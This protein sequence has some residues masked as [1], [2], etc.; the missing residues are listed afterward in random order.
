MITKLKP[1]PRSDK[2]LD[3]RMDVAS[4][5]TALVIFHSVNMLYEWEK[6][7]VLLAV[8]WLKIN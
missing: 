2:K 1:I 8:G 7:P 3:C 5:I 4:A 6:N